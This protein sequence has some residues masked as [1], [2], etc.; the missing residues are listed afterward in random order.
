MHFI[1][2]CISH[3]MPSTLS[4][5]SKRPDKYRMNGWMDEGVSSIC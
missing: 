4:T 3:K 1:Y 2:P 5:Q